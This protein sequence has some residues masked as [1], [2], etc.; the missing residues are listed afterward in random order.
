MIRLC[1]FSDEYSPNILEQIEGL[2]SNNISLMEIRG[3]N[4]KNILDLTLDEAK[5]INDLL[6]QNNIHVWSIGSPIGKVDINC[7]IEQYYNKVEHICKIANIFNA[8]N[9]RMFSFFNAYD[10]RDLVIKYLNNFC[11]ISS[12]YN[13]YMN[14][15][16]EKDVYGDT[17][18]RVLDLYNNVNNMKF[19]YDPANYIQCN[20][21]SNESIDKLF[22]ITNYFHIKDVIKE[23]GQ[24]VPAGYG[25]GQIDKIIK[26]INSDVVLTLEPHL[27]EFVGYSNIDNTSLKT[28]FKFSNNYEAFNF[29]VKA[30]KDILV[31]NGYKEISE[32]FER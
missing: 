11:N 21:D 9:I 8:K 26:L 3:V 4:G 31:A 29:A 2:K 15:E 1:A 22:N 18:E 12:K 17:V 30:L 13:V 5:V 25:D 16:N 6:A 28:K 32:G 20:Q 7:D 10:N 14:H 24:V 23:T 27:S 19:V